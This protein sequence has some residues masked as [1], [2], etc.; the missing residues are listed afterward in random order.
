M[1]PLI[2]V[3]F[4]L[5]AVVGSAGIA[6]PASAE[7][8]CRFT[9]DKYVGDTWVRDVVV[10]RH[11]GFANVTIDFTSPTCDSPLHLSATISARVTFADGGWIY[12]GDMETYG[13]NWASYDVEFPLTAGCANVVVETSEECVL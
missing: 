13:I 8:W 4:V 1:R 10:S 9:Y 2:S 5:G 6:A 3:L 7:E 12:T 11:G